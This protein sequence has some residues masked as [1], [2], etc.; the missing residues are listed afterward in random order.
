MHTTRKLSGIAVGVAFVVGLAADLLVPESGVS[1]ALTR[2]LG[3][4]SI[5]FALWMLARIAQ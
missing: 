1:A 5:G 2:V 4:S 3:A